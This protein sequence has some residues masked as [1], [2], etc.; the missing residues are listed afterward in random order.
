V[1]EPSALRRFVRFLSSSGLVTGDL[2]PEERRPALLLTVAFFL[3]AAAIVVGRAAADALFLAHLDT[4]ELPRLYAASALLAGALGAGALLARRRVPVDLLFPLTVVV[5][6]SLLLLA[7]FGLASGTNPWLLRGIFAG[8]ETAGTLAAVELWLLLDEIFPERQETRFFRFVQACAAGA[9]IV[10]GGGVALASRWIAPRDLLIAS[11][12]LLWLAGAPGLALVILHPRRGKRRASADAPRTG[13]GLPVGQRFLLA[14]F[15]LLGVVATVLAD[16][17]LK[18]QAVLFVSDPRELAGLFGQVACLAGAVAVLVHLGSRLRFGFLGVLVAAPLVLAGGAAFFVAAGGLLS[19]VVANASGVALSFSTHD[20]TVQR[21]FL[22][23]PRSVRHEAR[24]LVEGV[25]RPLGVAL[26]AVLL[27]EALRFPDSS[28]LIAL[29]AAGSVAILVPLVW[30]LRARL[31]PRR[32]PRSLARQGGVLSAEATR[33]VETGLGSNDPETVASALEIAHLAADDLTALVLPHLTSDQPSIRVLVAQYLADR[34]TPSVKGTLEGLLGDPDP[35][36]CAA[37]IRGVCALEG[38]DAVELVQP[39]L[40]AEDPHVLAAA[41]T[42]LVIFAGGEASDA[43]ARLLGSEN[44][45]DREATARALGAIG[46]RACVPRAMEMLLDDHDPGVRDAAIE[47]AGK[48]LAPELLPHLVSKLADGHMVRAAE[49]ALQRYGEEALALIAARHASDR[50]VLARVFRILGR[51]GTPEAIRFLVESLYTPDEGVRAE[52]CR[53][54][55][56]AVRADTS[57]KLERKRIAATCLVEI[58]AA[59]RTLAA[60]QT[61]GLPETAPTERFDPRVVERPKLATE[62]LRSALEEKHERA[63]ERLFLLLG[64]LYPNVPL[65]ADAAQRAVTLEALDLIRDSTLR[66]RVRPLLEWL[67]RLEKLATASGILAPPKKTR[68][69][70]LRELLSD[71]SPWVVTCAAAYAGA[72]GV[73]AVK[74]AILAH[75]ERPNPVLRET[76]LEALEALVP[77]EE[78]PRAVAPVIWDEYEPIRKRVDKDLERIIDQV[79]LNRAHGA[80][81]EAYRT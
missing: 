62:L 76:A 28:R 8:V 55:W 68:D 26:A 9:A 27:I 58:A 48:I 12:V 10:G 19:L 78:L 2:T 36:V 67:P 69:E 14:G 24:L 81:E 45:A 59:Y 40:S 32:L 47:A 50:A 41:A 17:V 64:S 4:R 53:A 43:L 31:G 77:I 18:R 80:L 63:L 37:A 74:D 11:T 66:G 57:V 3:V 33:A 38:R 15:V 30:G 23:V 6:G 20:T 65:S 21:A 7:R 16:F 29:G 79:E 75:L 70:W 71:E 73:T 54:I 72:F 42:G 39:Y 5:L 22:A 34:A 61:F 51:I 25:L 56:R 1:T 46:T 52:I 60:A 13:V 35:L 44:A 49:L